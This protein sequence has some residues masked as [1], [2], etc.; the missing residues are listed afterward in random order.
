MAAAFGSMFIA[1]AAEL[2]CYYYAFI[3]IPALLWEKRREVGWWLLALTAFSEFA[4]FGHD[5]GFQF[6][7]GWLDEQYTLISAVTVGVFAYVWY[8]FSPWG[9]AKPYEEEDDDED[10]VAEDAADDE[11]DADEEKPAARKGGGR[12]PARKGNRRATA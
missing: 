12:K 8:L 4:S 7:P 10:E 1:I 11:A 5:K 2:T 6:M 3:I 9:E